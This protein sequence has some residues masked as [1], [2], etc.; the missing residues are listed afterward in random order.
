MVT[1]QEGKPVF[2]AMMERFMGSKSNH[3]IQYCVFDVLYF[4]GEKVTHLPLLERKELLESFIELTDI[5]TKVQW[6]RGNGKDYFALVK[7]HGLEGIVLKKADSKYLANK[8]SHNWIKVINYLQTETF[9]LGMR[10]KKFGLLLGVEEN[11]AI[12]PAGIMEFM[13]TEAKK[14][15]YESY[16]KHVRNETKDFIFLDPNMKCRVKF[17]NY[18]KSGKLR[19]PSFVAYV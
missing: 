18:T 14:T 2:E 3:A 11:Q 16:R 15:F 1:D 5:V 7:E 17:R 12:K 13:N 9:I 6:M 10:K 8:R 19:V 4:E